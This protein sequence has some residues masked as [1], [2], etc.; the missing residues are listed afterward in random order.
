[1]WKPSSAVLALIAALAA[2]PTALPAQSCAA[3]DP[4]RE[5]L[6]AE[7]R[8]SPPRRVSL[9]D[10]DNGRVRGCLGDLGTDESALAKSLAKRFAELTSQEEFADTWP[11]RRDA[12]RELIQLILRGTLNDPRSGP[13][14]RA[15]NM[16]LDEL[17]SVLQSALTEPSAVDDHVQRL[18]DP[19]SWAYRPLEDSGDPGHRPFPAKAHWKVHPQPMSADDP[20]ISPAAA[21]FLDALVALRAANLTQV[22]LLATTQDL[23]TTLTKLESLSAQWTTYFEG[24][25]SQYLLE[26]LV[27]SG[28]V[29]RGCSTDSRGQGIGWCEVPTN[30]I[31]LLH[32]DVVMEYVS[33]ADDGQQLDPSTDCR[34]RRLQPLELVDEIGRRRHN[35]GC[36]RRLPRGH[37]LRPRRRRRHRRRPP[38]SPRPQVLARRHLPKERLGHRRQR[39]PGESL[40]QGEREDARADQEGTGIGK[41][42]MKPSP[43]AVAMGGTSRSGAFFPAERGVA[44]RLV[45]IVHGLNGSPESLAPLRRAIQKAAPNSDLL[46]FRFPFGLF[47]TADA[48]EVAADLVLEL[49]RRVSAQAG[50]TPYEESLLVGH[51][52][53]GLL[54]R[55]AYCY[56][57]GESED[58]VLEPAAVARLGGVAGQACGQHG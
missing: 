7:M 11:L 15:L 16:N 32:P 30:Q 21:Q 38:I 42:V 44:Q 25:R 19:D 51:S 14:T 24:T 31:I 36:F 56:A 10:L 1:M 4:T 17:V 9:S 43:L 35:H 5:V 27:N 40:D 12:A 23:K 39:R 6:V 54:C 28:R 41:A 48:A 47:S 46:V 29:T 37:L 45:A 57:C 33:N 53:G 20:E 2:A 13:I 8:A 22:V 26:L 55:K 18:F 3:W 52:I 49:D 58:A 50:N 34:S